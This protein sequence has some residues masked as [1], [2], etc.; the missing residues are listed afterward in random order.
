MQV[1][2]KQLTT[3][4]ISD[5]PGATKR[6]QALTEL[7][8]AK[9]KLCDSVCPVL[10]CCTKNGRHTLVM[11]LQNHSLQDLLMNAPGL[12]QTLLSAMQLNQCF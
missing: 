10:G 6:F 3:A 2:V 8:V 9:S 11:Q 5:V 4:A 7:A 1:A 12:H